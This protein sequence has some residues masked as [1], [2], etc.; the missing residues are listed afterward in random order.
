MSKLPD[1]IKTLVKESEFKLKEKGSVFISISQPVNSVEIIELILNSVKKKYHDATHYCY[2]YKI[3]D[4][5]FKYSDSGEPS[6]TA[7]IRIYNAQN[8]FG[9]TNLLTIVVRYFG[10]TK[11][12]VGPL[13]KAYYEAAFQNLQLSELEEQILCDQIE[14]RYEYDQS[15]LIHHLISKFSLVIEKNLFETKPII[16]CSIPNTTIKKF[17]TDLKSLS[18]NQISSKLLNKPFYTKKQIL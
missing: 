10:G 5:S 12:G 6:G 9:L 14:I 2:S 3:V 8:Y 11:L 16:I 17:S 4:C 1:K 13:G 18:N 15:K 7:G